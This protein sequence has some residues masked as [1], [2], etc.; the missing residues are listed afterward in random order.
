MFIA[1]NVKSEYIDNDYL[2]I[3]TNHYKL[4]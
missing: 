2:I 3:Y 4:K 1:K